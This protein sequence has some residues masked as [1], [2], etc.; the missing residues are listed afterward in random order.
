MECLQQSAFSE[1]QKAQMA[2]AILA[3]IS[4][5]I[6]RVARNR[7]T[8]RVDDVAAFLPESDVRFLEDSQ[9]TLILQ[10]KVQ[11]MAAVLLCSCAST[12]AIRMRPHLAKR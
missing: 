8:Q 3:Q 9:Y 12:V 7:P 1:Q 10:A 5:S 2:A 4:A 11:R 6:N